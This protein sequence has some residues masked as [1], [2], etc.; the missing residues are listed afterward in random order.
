MAKVRPIKPKKPVDYVGYEPVMLAVSKA[1]AMAW[2]LE[3]LG[4][5]GGAGNNLVHALEDLGTPEETRGWLHSVV[6]D[7]LRAAL[8][9]IEREYRKLGTNLLEKEAAALAKPKD[10]A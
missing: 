6:G 1:R 4:E 5:T 2:V 7:A 10:G 3:E 8:D 9:E